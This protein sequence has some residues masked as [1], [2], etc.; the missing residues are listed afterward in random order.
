MT[1]R[2]AADSWINKLE[3]MSRGSRNLILILLVLLG[4]MS[5]QLSRVTT[6]LN[7][8]KKNKTLK[9]QT[10]AA[11]H[12]CIESLSPPEGTTA[13][14]KIISLAFQSATEIDFI[15]RKE[16][17]LARW[18]RGTGGLTDKDQTLL[19]KYYSSA[20]SVFEYGLGESTLIASH[21]GVPR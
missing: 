11:H 14:Q 17:Q 16:F 9:T 3:T 10:A 8:L 2:A 1:H 19:V 4:I 5:M 18:I 7:D 15:P 21:V 13:F 20:S 12:Y 6:E